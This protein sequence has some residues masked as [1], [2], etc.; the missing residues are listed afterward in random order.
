MAAEGLGQEM[1]HVLSEKRTQV[2]FVFDPSLIALSV[3]FITHR[4]FFQ[5]IEEKEK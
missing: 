2:S 4:V 5:E 1:G 3:V